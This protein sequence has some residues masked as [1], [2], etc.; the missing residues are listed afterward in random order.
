MG[1][2]Q[3]LCWRNR[4]PFNLIWNMGHEGP[5]LKPRCIGPGRART[6]LLFYSILFYPGYRFLT[7]PILASSGLSA[8]TSAYVDSSYCI[9]LWGLSNVM[10]IASIFPSPPRYLPPGWLSFHHGFH[11]QVSNS[12][13]LFLVPSSPSYRPISTQVPKPYINV[14]CRI[15]YWAGF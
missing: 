12:L 4:A 10:L 9:P 14:N 5:V 13:R 8:R 6:Q 3:K 7:L 1:S 2:H 11:R 15:W